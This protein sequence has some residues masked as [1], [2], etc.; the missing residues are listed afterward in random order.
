MDEWLRLHAALPLWQQVIAG[1]VSALAIYLLLLAVGRWL[2]RRRGLHLGLAYQTGALS[3]AG[4]IVARVLF[5]AWDLRRELGAAAI[6]C[7]VSALLPL[8]TQQFLPWFFESRRKMPV[9]RFLREVLGIVIVLATLLLV[10]Q[11]DY[12]VQIPGLI[13]GSGIV[14]LA[15]GLAA[16]DLLGNLIA[17]FTLHFGR[18][19]QVGDWLLLDHQHVQVTEINWRSTRFRTPDDVQLDVPNAHIVKQ[20]ITNYSGH[21]RAGSVGERRPHGL[22]L[23]VGVEYSAPPNRVRDVLAGAAAAAPGILAQPAPEVFVKGFGDSAVTYEVR[24]WIDD[25]ARHNPIAD[26]VRTNIWYAL[27]REC[28][29]IPFPVRTVH[30]ERRAPMSAQ[31]HGERQAQFRAMLAAQPVFEVIGGEDLEFLLE[32]C[33]AHRF[34][35]GENIIAEGDDGDSMFVLTIGRA[36]VFIGRRGSQQTVAQFKPGDCFGEMSLLTGE[37]RSA[38]VQAATDCE[39]LEITKEVFGEVVKRQQD[40]ITRLS[41]LLA[42]RRM[43]REGF[44][45]SRKKAGTA[46][47]ERETEYKQSFLTRLK[48]FFE[49]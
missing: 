32:N 22:R 10:L 35:R 42:R 15:I 33:P 6:I 8:F 23:E 27:R 9:P 19:F 11:L 3:T 5:P 31:R 38:T 41:E 4:W 18:P 24:Y 17:G 26:A 43:E 40:I 21:R 16:Q 39:V 7:A 47:S 14:A 37:K 20:T 49:L 30:V 36:R 25:H 45:A 1:V 34:G 12:D 48:G 2:K 44:T 46:E 28:L 29:S 13:A